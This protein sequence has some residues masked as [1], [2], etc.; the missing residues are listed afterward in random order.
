M[1]KKTDKPERYP[2]PKDIPQKNTIFHLPNKRYDQ[3]YPAISYIVYIDPEEYTD[4][5]ENSHYSLA[6]EAVYKLALTLP[7]KQFITI[8]PKRFGWS[9]DQ[10]EYKFDIVTQKSAVVLEIAGKNNS[11]TRT[12]NPPFYKKGAD[13]PSLT[14]RSR[15]NSFLNRAFISH[16]PNVI[17]RF[18]PEHQN[19]E[20]MIRLIDLSALTG[21]QTLRV[22]MNSE[23]KEAIGYLAPNIQSNGAV[24]P[25]GDVETDFINRRNL[26]NWRR[27]MAE[28]IAEQIDPKRFG[29]KNIYL[30]GSAKNNTAGPGSDVDLM[31]HI[32]GSKAQR[33]ELQVWLEGWSKCLA[34]I[35]YLKSGYRSDGLLDIHFINDESIAQKTSFAIKINA[36]TDA[37]LCLPMANAKS[38]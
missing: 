9:D 12:N 21:N 27:Y 13:T 11:A 31:I 4:P 24:H 33:D 26:A 10:F 32:E 28:K 7:P 38:R 16:S 36:V 37:A 19:L 25:P 8:C 29:V 17:S 6:H 34:E 18:L 2:I 20:Y 1:K 5:Y 22:S 14:L 35:N 15:E 30:I 23:L 3:F